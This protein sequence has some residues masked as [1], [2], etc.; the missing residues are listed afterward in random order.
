M[1][2]PFMN[3]LDQKRYMHRPVYV[4][5]SSFIEGLNMTKNMAYALI[6]YFLETGTKNLHTFSVVQLNFQ[7]YAV[8][9]G[10]LLL[11][12]NWTAEF[13]TMVGPIE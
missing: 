4:A 5:H 12:L 10:N 8:P 13:P 1:C 11:N 9:M 2:D 7:K 6:L 3:D